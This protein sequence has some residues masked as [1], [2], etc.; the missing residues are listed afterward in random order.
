MPVDVGTQSL[1]QQLAADMQAVWGSVSNPRPIYFLSPATAFADRDLHTVPAS[2]WDLMVR[3]FILLQNL[4]V[5][6][7]SIGAWQGT[8][9]FSLTGHFRY[10][11]PQSN[12]VLMD[13]KET[14][15]NRLIG[16]LTQSSRY[17]GGWHRVVSVD[18]QGDAAD[19]QLR[20]VHTVT[21]VWEWRTT[22]G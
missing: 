13:V 20:E 18:Y 15:A 9:Q 2:A 19:E 8:Y 5:E 22:V 10:P 12:L 16:R 1:R 4:E 17:E 11:L 6:P 3:G 14:L 21:V 7:Q